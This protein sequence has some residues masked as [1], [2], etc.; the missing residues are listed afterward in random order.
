MAGSVARAL[1]FGAAA[2]VA[3]ANAKDIRV[4]AGSSIQSAINSANSRDRIVVDAGEYREQLLITKSNIELVG[5]NGAV[6]IP[7]ESFT[8][9]GCSGLAGD[10]S[11]AGICI[12]GADVVLEDW[13]G[14]EHKRV[15]SVGSYVEKVKVQGLEI[16]AFPL[17]IAII[18]AKNAEI[19]KNTV[20]DGTIYGIL[21]VGSIGT[22]ITYNTVR[23]DFNFIGIGF[24]DT[25]DVAVT[26]NT[27]TGYQIALS[28][29]TNGADV[30]HNKVATPC[31]AINVDPG[32]DGARI[33]HNQVGPSNGRCY[34]DFGGFATGIL[35]AG[36]T[37]TEVRHN[38]VTG[39][40]DGGSEYFAAA[41]V[42]ILEGVGNQVTHNTLT[43]NEQDLVVEGGGPNEVAHN[44]CDTPP[45][46]CKK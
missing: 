29:R 36:A 25:S 41:G 24:A 6:L 32:F 13:P 33:T 42:A 8:S 40:T 5:K 16:H 4:K 35:L 44:K 37:N 2:L 27:I 28:V 26:Q 12:L 31:V 15:V 14:Y 17:D 21:T 34:A 9:N 45:E 20:V 19:R 11:Q 46:L 38:K 30:G 10:G 3:I 22:L 23:S 7:P 43:G 18:G 1:L 39:Q